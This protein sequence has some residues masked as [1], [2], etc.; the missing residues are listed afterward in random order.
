MDLHLTAY[1]QWLIGVMNM[2]VEEAVEKA[3]NKLERQT[4]KGLTEREKWDLAGCFRRINP[5]SIRR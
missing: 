2:G 5:Y 1:V 4:G 3:S